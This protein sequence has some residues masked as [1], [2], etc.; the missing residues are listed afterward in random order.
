ME[1]LKVLVRCLTGA[2]VMRVCHTMDPVSDDPNLIGFGG[3]PAVMWPA[4]VIS[5]S[6]FDGFPYAAVTGLR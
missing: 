6:G 3:L 2:L 5:D 4:T 1:L